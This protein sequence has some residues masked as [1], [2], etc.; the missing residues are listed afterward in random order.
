MNNL[1]NLFLS[2]PLMTLEEYFDFQ[3]K[4]DTKYEFHNG[5]LYP[6]PGG[7]V[8]HGAIGANV[9]FSV[10]SELRKIKSD[11]KTLSSDVK[12]LITKTNKILFPDVSVYCG[13]LDA[14]I[15]GR[16]DLVANPSILFE[17]LSPSTE[18]K[19]FG[20]KFDEYKSIKSLKQYVL[21][22]QTHAFVEVRTLINAEEN[23]WKIESFKNINDVLKLDSI[24]IKLALADIYED[25]EFDK[26]EEII[27]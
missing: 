14:G 9:I 21:I 23:L 11:C 27:A 18:A 19:D 3:E 12:I 25:I 15:S 5:K 20:E 6:T 2:R 26:T 24:N 1:L 7:S 22:Q 8:R 16:T 13:D 10:K 17:V 4:A